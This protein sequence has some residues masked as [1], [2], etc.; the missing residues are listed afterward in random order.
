MYIIRLMVNGFT[1]KNLHRKK[2]SVS[3]KTDDDAHNYNNDIADRVRKK[4]GKKKNK[5]KNYPDFYLSRLLD[6]FRQYILLLLLLFLSVKRL[7]FH[8]FTCYFLFLFLTIDISLLFFFFSKHNTRH[9]KLN[10]FEP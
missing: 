10:V 6:I 4:M 8:Y 2:F 9:D 3:L 1:T 5:T 7:C